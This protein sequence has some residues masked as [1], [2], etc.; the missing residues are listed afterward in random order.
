M[1]TGNLPVPPVPKKRKS[2][3]DC[4]V[5][6]QC[7]GDVLSTA[8]QSSLEKLICSANTRQDDEML[9]RVGSD[10]Q[11]RQFLWHSLCYATYTSAQNIR[12]ASVGN[13]E[14]NTSKKY[15]SEE[16]AQSAERVSRR[17]ETPALDWSKCLFCKNKTYKKCSQLINIATF[18][19]SD[20][21]LKAA[22]R[23]K[24]YSM[25]HVL[26]SVRNDLI[27]A[28]AKYHKACYS[29]YVLKKQPPPSDTIESVYDSAF[30]EIVD[31]VTIGMRAGK[32]Y[33][34]TPLAEKYRKIMKNKGVITGYST[35]RLKARLQQHFGDNIVF[36]QPSAPRKSE[37]L[38][39]STLMVKDILK[40]WADLEQMNDE[41]IEK[42]IF[43]VASF[44]KQQILQ[45]KGITIK[46]LNV[47]DVSLNTAQQLI[48]E[49]LHLLLRLLM[50]DDISKPSQIVS[51]S[52]GCTNAYEERKVLSIA[53]DVIYCAKKSRV[54][55]PKHV[56]LAM[57]INHLTS[58]KVLI[59]L[60]NRMGHSCS[61]DDL[62]EMDTS[63]AA[64]VL[65]KAKESGAVMP[66]NITPGAFVQ[67]AADNNDINEETLDGKNTTHATTMVIYQKKTFGPQEAPKPLAEHH[68]RR[69]S[70][71]SEE[72][73]IRL[74]DC[75]VQGHRPVVKDF[76]G[77]VDEKW[78]T[79]KSK[80]FE[81]V[82]RN[83]ITWK[84]VR[85]N[86]R[87][88]TQA[89]VLDSTELQ[90]T[91]SWSAFNALLY[92][93]IPRVDNIGYCPLIE[94]PSTEFSTIYTVLKHAQAISAIVGQKNTV[95]T[96]DLA[97]YMKAKQLQ[98]KFA[99]EFRDVVIR[100]GG[101]H[102][103]LNFLAVIGKKYASSGLD[104]LFIE[105]GVYGSGATTTLMKGKSY[106]RGIRA[107]KLTT[108]AFFRLLW[109]AFLRWYEDNHQGEG[110]PEESVTLQ[111]IK[112]CV[113]VVAKKGEVGQCI[114]DLGSQL[115][116]TMGMFEVFKSTRRT[117][118]KKFAF[119]EE[120]MSMVNILLQFVKA[121]RTAD[122]QLHLTTVAA[123]LPHFFAMDR[124]N[125]SRWLPI[126]LADMNNLKAAH[127]SVQEE[128]I[129]GGHAVSR[130][131]HPFA[132]VWTD[133]A[134]EQSIN[135]DSKSKGGI[136]G[137]SQNPA[138]LSRW[139]LTAH[140][141]AGITAALKKMY[142]LCP[143]SESAHKEAGT[144]RV[145]RD[146]R[147]VQKLL[148]CFSGGLMEDPFSEETSED[149][150]NFATG[151]VLPTELAD[152]LI[153]CTERG[154]QQMSSFIN[155]RVN[156]NDVSFWDAIEKLKVK[157]FMATTKT[158]RLKAA[159]EK[160]ITVKA[161]RDLFGRLLIVA[162]VREV[163]LR[164]VLSYELSA[165]PCS[166][167]HQ[168]GTLR[169]TVKSVM[170][171]LLEENVDSPPRLPAT[172][173]SI[174]FVIDA[175]V[176]MHKSAGAT[177]FGDLASKYFAI[178]TSHLTS[179]NCSAVHL[180]LDQYWPASIKAGER[181]RR[182]S[183]DAREV[184]IVSANT[185]V[186]KQWA[187]FILNPKNKVNLCDFLAT[188]FCQLGQEI[189]QEGKTLIIAGGFTDGEIT[190]SVSRGSPA[191]EIEELRSNHEEADTR[192]V[193]H[194]AYATRQSPSLIVIQTPD[195]DVLILAITHFAAIGCQ[196]LWLRTGTRDRHRN[197]P[198]HVIHKN[199]GEAMS[200]ALP[201]LHA[202]TGC[203]TTSS[204]A[205][206]GKKKPWK[207]AKRDTEHQRVLGQFGCARESGL[208]EMIAKKVETFICSLYP[209]T[210]RSTKTTD[211][212]RYLL[213]CQKRKGK[214]EALPP[215]SDSLKQHLE[216]ACYQTR[217]WRGALVAMQDLGSP[218]GHGWEVGE[219]GTLRPLLMSQA[220]AP[221]SVVE[222]TT[223]NCDKSHCKG[224]C[225]CSNNG[226]SCTEACACMADESC[227]NPHGVQ[228][229]SGETDDEDDV[230]E[231]DEED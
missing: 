53:Q 74:Q 28:E 63:L 138:A 100:V 227:R 142:D 121:E 52:P 229:I 35:Q 147:D 94:G 135:A 27:A 58:C 44:V 172:E 201:A 96:F 104:D 210:R 163:N 225:S 118:S 174:V 189:L 70:L 75:S 212:L 165:V 169:K 86:E 183:S 82:S 3:G 171:S 17:S 136:V 98:W 18:E 197:V 151:V 179:T 133:M 45:V 24:D 217:I 218:I 155:K 102:I 154:R 167:A 83:D 46:P 25:L 33:E 31:E 127:P 143:S 119:W 219:D 180:V 213:F 16:V 19:A 129:L 222:L 181:N 14:P 67:I 76:V 21:V 20:N 173:R 176:Q 195:T 164:D 73:V 146:E 61:Y 117:I 109:K 139:F 166:L 78:F 114:Q 157:T 8:K 26:G 226:L 192:M 162:G 158:I 41:G 230:D 77:R 161:D 223:C 91:P 185:P 224:N 57:S 87:S 71:Q 194:A 205:D 199:L 105:S 214:N 49:S 137:I 148:D 175:M 108:E 5:I 64:E 150:I 208:D 156:A 65:A 131:T 59:Q 207:V 38:C 85:L 115:E 23:R 39:G 95:I 168:D 193:L 159:D 140:E 196:E 22:E 198:V 84:I 187:K 216:R 184:K 122:W 29:L 37:L 107:H 72:G 88:L 30:R 9:R 6:C 200:L 48:P 221:S 134:L 47:A 188:H 231:V 66:S 113:N 56:S 4:C 68:K 103:A 170:A 79:E 145:T 50:T 132:Q 92:P 125:Y 191:E 149:L 40:A 1:D 190:V 177:T 128:F 126:Y 80:E 62:R 13:S 112:E 123:M 116:N 51:M 186:P 12:Y 141:R 11:N 10:F 228:H 34:M 130:S 211:E 99:G 42:D 220:A 101:F 43:R 215:T 160:L 178:V 93:D 81:S 89:R 2:D 15:C 153:S 55:L 204:M 120:Y 111:K 144:K 90:T 106:N 152:A 60:L 182:G 69:R 110:I 202:I 124:P 7:S 203:D 209:T 206:I 36:H 54:K 32:A 97:I